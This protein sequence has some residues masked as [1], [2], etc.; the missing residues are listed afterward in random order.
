[1]ETSEQRSVSAYERLDSPRERFFGWFPYLPKQAVFFVINVLYFL[2]GFIVWPYMPRFML[3]GGI[4]SPFVW[5]VLLW[6]PVNMVLWGV[7]FSRYWTALDD[8]DVE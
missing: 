7:Y 8:E 4:P 3:F 6:T 1:V 2:S 5:Y